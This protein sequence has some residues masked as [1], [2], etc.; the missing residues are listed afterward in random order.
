MWCHSLYFYFIVH[1][2][3]IWEWRQLDDRF[4]EWIWVFDWISAAGKSG[5]CSLPLWIS[6]TSSPPPPP[7]KLI[8][9]IKE[10]F[11]QNNSLLVCQGFMMLSCLLQKCCTSSS[12][13]SLPPLKLNVAGSIPGASTRNLLLWFSPC[14]LFKKFEQSHWNYLCAWIPEMRNCSC[15][16][17][18]SIN[19]LWKIYHISDFRVVPIDVDR[20]TLMSWYF[21]YKIR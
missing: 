16:L 3:Y 10:C 18:A 21:L 2:Q 15:F 6:G 13:I 5:A 1:G 12:S 8:C 9:I 14:L 17:C 4:Y 20:R 19:C 7:P 11:W